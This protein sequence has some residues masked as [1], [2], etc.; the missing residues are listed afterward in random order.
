MFMSCNCICNFVQYLGPAGISYYIFW[1]S[2]Q[3]REITEGPLAHFVYSRISH[4]A[5][6]LA[7]RHYSGQSSA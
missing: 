3:N 4:Y 6:E 7:G 5:T 1:F 2:S